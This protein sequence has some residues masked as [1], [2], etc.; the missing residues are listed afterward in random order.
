MTDAEPTQPAATTTLNLIARRRESFEGI[1]P[2]EA[3]A[4]ACGRLPQ[5]RGAY[6]RL[7]SILHRANA[8]NNWLFSGYSIQTVGRK[9]ADSTLGDGLNV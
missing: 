6:I 9:T 4:R 3:E 8:G 2:S 7:K 5:L 1:G